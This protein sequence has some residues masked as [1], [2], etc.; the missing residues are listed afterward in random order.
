MIIN[1][2]FCKMELQDWL[3]RHGLKRTEAEPLLNEFLKGYKGPVVV[4]LRGIGKKV[5]CYPRRV[6]WPRLRAFITRKGFK[7]SRTLL[8]PSERKQFG[9]WGKEP[10][11][12]TRL[13]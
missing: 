11:G 13:Y 4:E 7:L 9:P 10:R 12:R 3:K 5:K 8:D 2:N 6:I 1:K